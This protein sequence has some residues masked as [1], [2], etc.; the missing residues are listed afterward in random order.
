MLREC[1]LGGGFQSISTRGGQTAVWFEKPPNRDQTE[2]LR[3][4]DFPNRN[5]TAHHQN[6]T[7]PNRGLRGLVGLVSRFSYT[8]FFFLKKNNQKKKKSNQ[9][10]KTAT[11]KKKTATKKKKNSKPKKKQQ[12]KKKK[13]ARTK[14]NSIN[15]SNQF[16][17]LMN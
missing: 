11:K 5:Q 16:Q 2:G 1:R 17:A 4:G 13:T 6:R 10:K 15:T 9:K 3:F 8:L 14:K 12:A 7:K